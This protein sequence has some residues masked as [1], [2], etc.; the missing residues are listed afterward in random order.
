MGICRV[1]IEPHRIML[2]CCCCYVML[3][4]LVVCGWGVFG[5]RANRQFIRERETCSQWYGWNA[6]RSCK[7][8]ELLCWSQR[9]ENSDRQ[10]RI[11]WCIKYVSIKHRWKIV[12][13][14]HFNCNCIST[15]LS[16]FDSTL[17]V[18]QATSS[19]VEFL[20]N[21]RRAHSSI[22]SNESSSNCALHYINSFNVRLF[23][24]S[25][26]SHSMLCVLCF[27]TL[28]T[29]VQFLLNRKIMTTI[30][31]RDDQKVWLQP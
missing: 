13:L 21:V 14:F 19:R 28:L 31:Q 10:E 8:G 7:L 5:C 20:L 17:F 2:I 27:F 9:R 15:S 30:F 24:S 3:A 25:I 29:F 12:I 26:D 4:K 1:I 11:L 6:R 23:A 16:L 18:E 22:G